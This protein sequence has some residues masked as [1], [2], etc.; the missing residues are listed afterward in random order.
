MKQH[1]PESASGG[2]QGRCIKCQKLPVYDSDQGKEH[3]VYDGCLGKLK[4]DIMN[5]CCGHGCD[6]QAYIQYW[7]GDRLG[8][9]EAI[10]EQARL[11]KAT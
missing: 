2:Q 6:S 7:G 5:A 10:A 11:T 4:G 8:G 1:T 3:E 9:D